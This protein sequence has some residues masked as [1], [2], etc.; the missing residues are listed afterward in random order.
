MFSRKLTVAAIV[1]AATVVPVLAFAAPATAPRAAHCVFM[2]HRVTAVQALRLTERNGRGTSERLAGA[3]VFVQA[4]PGLT[5]EWLQLTV[6][7]HI[8]QMNSAGMANCP[9]DA[10]DVR[11]SVASAGPGFAVNITGKN[12]AQANEILRRAQLLVR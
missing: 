9:L 12:T 10:K 6:Q 4:E 2:E 7:R 3:Q 8:T 11:V 1:A 5:A